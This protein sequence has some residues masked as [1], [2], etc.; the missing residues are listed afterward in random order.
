M[1][2]FMKQNNGNKNNNINNII[3]YNIIIIIKIIVWSQ[4]LHVPN[5]H[6]TGI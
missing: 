3:I 6:L 5:N 4:L 2:A 1:Y